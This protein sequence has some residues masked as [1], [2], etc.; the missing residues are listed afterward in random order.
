MTESQDL[1]GDLICGENRNLPSGT[2]LVVL[3][4][5]SSILVGMCESYLVSCGTVNIWADQ[6]SWGRPVCI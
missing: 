3:F 5:H 2:L 4:I 1:R 6:S